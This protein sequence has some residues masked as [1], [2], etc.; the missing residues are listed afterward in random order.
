MQPVNVVKKKDKKV[1]MQCFDPESKLQILGSLLILTRHE[2]TKCI[3]H[4]NAVH[5]YS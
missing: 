4:W 5:V 1:A 2:A 3:L